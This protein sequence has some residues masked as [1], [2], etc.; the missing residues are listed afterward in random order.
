[1]YDTRPNLIIGF[2]GCDQA[3]ADQLLITPDTIKISQE[4]YDW[5]GH[6]FYCWENNPARALLWAKDKEARGRIKKP[7]IIG[8][9]IDMQRCCDLLDT[10]YIQMLAGYYES[11]KTN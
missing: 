2:H 10:N 5:L 1:M 6:G 3:V 8:A 11:M 7:A 9:V 4:T